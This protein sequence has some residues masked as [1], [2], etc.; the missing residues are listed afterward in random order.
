MMSE[1][2]Y[3][4]RLRELVLSGESFEAPPEVFPTLD[5]ALKAFPD[6]ARLWVR[7]GMA[8]QLAPE[9]S[10]WTLEDSLASFEKAAA[11]DPSDA[12]A[13]E[14]IGYFHDVHTH[15]YPR[16]EQAFRRAVELGAGS[17]S[18]EGL[19]RVLAELGR[20]EEAL[21]AL[22]KFPVKDSLEDLE[23][24]AR[25]DELEKEIAAGLWDPDSK[26]EPGGKTG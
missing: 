13:F 10:S 16:A 3:L 18:Y 12:S 4:E 7:R 21:S 8:I 1:D 19:S 2:E 5:E 24:E 22:R 14:E 9:D 26:S 25:R 23:G 11:L 15:D 20:R 6:S 17:R